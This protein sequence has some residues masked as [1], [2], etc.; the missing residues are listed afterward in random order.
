[1]LR[2]NLPESITLPCGTVLD[3]KISYTA[4]V[5]YNRRVL[6]N[7]IKKLG[8]KYRCVEVLARRLRGQEDLHR[9]PYRPTTWILTN[10]SGVDFAAPGALATPSDGIPVPP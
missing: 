8:G 1:M 10:C 9:R 3:H 7:K 2:T 4:G 6:L 5:G